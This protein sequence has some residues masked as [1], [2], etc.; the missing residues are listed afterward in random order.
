ML[1]LKNIRKTYHIGDIET[2]AIDDISVSFREKE[3]VSILGTSGSGKTTCLNI[4]GGLDRYDSG[5]LV[6]KGKKTSSFKDKDWDAY[7]NNSVGFIFQSYNLILHLSIVANVELGM[8]LSGMSAGERHKKAIDV[9][10][11]V[12]LKEHLHK[13]PGQL[14]GG[15]MQ[16]VA[17]ARALANDPEIL[18]CD[19]PTGALDTTTSGQIMDLIREVAKDR[20]VIM[21]T[22]NPD[23]AQKYSDRII[24]FQ[25]GKIISDTNPY[26]AQA[27]DSVFNLRK[28]SMSFFTALKISF[29]NIRTK[30]GRTFLTALASSIGIIGIAVILSLSSGFK[31]QIDK[32]QSDAMAEFP[33][34]ISQSAAEINAEN[35]A[36]MQ[37][38]MQDSMMGTQEY[39]Q[40]D[41]AFLY[42]PSESVFMHKN[43]LTDEY[44][45]YLDNIDP[46]ICSG[47]GYTYTVSMNMLRDVDGTVTPISLNSKS[48][49]TSVMSSGANATGLSSYP[50]LLKGEG[51][52]YLER[53][54]ELLDGSYPT[55]ATDIVLVVDTRNRI[56]KKILQG[57]GFETE[58]LDSVSFDKIVG[59]EFKII[60]NNNY[61]VKTPFGTYIPGQDYNAMYAADGNISV[62]ISGVIR[63]KDGETGILNPGIAYSDSLSKM[64]IESSKDSEIVAA[65]KASDTNVMTTEKLDEASKTSLLS[66]LGGNAAPYMVM[67]YPDNFEDKDAIIA[68]LDEYNKD[69]KT[70]DQIVYTDLAAT[71]SSMTGG[72]MDGITIVLIAFAGISL[73]VSLIMIC[74]ITYTSVLERTKEIG[75]LRALG[76]RKKDITRVFDAETCILGIFSGLLGILIA[77]LLTFPINIILFNLTEL[78]GVARLDPRYAIF[79]VVLSTV[80]TILGGHIPA[81]MASKK[82]AVE[83]LRSE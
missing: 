25:D 65:Q 9:L 1:E 2:K 45:G 12:G 56:D 52:T 68:Y 29:N 23:I 50:E 30:K 43:L 14:S 40:S 13:K 70:D 77:W 74:I 17:I 51:K 15:Q 20:L 11:R 41:K 49:S 37:S 24:R 61:Y 58:N 53:T 16:R 6:I 81:R 26:E 22:H 66:Y 34:I 46:E 72:I 3:F 67:L 31:V 8:T 76:A 80:L 54:Y 44:L 64:I 39:V 82:D 33:I 71:M 18:L 47:I 35:I 62:K 27:E 28:T 75:I 79:L 36:S 32:F 55:D 83:A 59:T 57:L 5:E 21:V 10:T 4:I 19:E 78:K 63:V 7:R 60:T 69:L 48:S 73:V 42:D 38:E